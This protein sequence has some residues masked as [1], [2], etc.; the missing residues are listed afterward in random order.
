MSE[1]TIYSDNPTMPATSVESAESDAVRA[2]VELRVQG[3][4][5]AP[6]GMHTVVS[7]SIARNFARLLPNSPL[8]ERVAWA[9]EGDVL[10]LWTVVAH[11]DRQLQRNIYR[12]ESQFLEACGG[13]LCDFVVVFRD[14]RNLADLLPSR[15]HVLIPE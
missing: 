2:E 15:A 14:D 4:S 1:L 6:L 13:R 9:W 5:F 11:R 10:R 3:R 12:A 7:K 8:I